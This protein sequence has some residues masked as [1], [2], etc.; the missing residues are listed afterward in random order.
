M[1]PRSRK[2]KRPKPTT[3]RKKK[4]GKGNE[5]KVKKENYVARTA[6]FFSIGT[7]F[8]PM[9]SVGTFYSTQLINHYALVLMKMAVDDATKLALGM[10]TI[11]L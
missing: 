6:A 9:I 11:N 4:K 5:K 3:I 1:M 8:L 2:L 7:F 10:I